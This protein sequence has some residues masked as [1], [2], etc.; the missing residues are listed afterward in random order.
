MRSDIILSMDNSIVPG[1]LIVVFRLHAGIT[2]YLLLKHKDGFWTFPGG[3]VEEKDTSLVMAAK[4]ELFEET[5]IDANEIEIINTRLK[6]EFVYGSEKSER[7][8]KK[9]ITHLFTL[10]LSHGEDP[11]PNSEI[12]EIKWTTKDEALRL[13]PFEDI[14][15]LFKRLPAK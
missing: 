1:V 15:D 7:S 9:G 11:K 8:G 14:K 5:L 6:N 13:L 3:K 12:I 2:E 10:K 4:R